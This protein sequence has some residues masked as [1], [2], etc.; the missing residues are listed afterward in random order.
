MQ[1]AG[2]VDA[3]ELAGESEIITGIGLLPVVLAIASGVMH[4]ELYGDLY[5]WPSLADSS[6]S[7]S[8]TGSSESRGF[9][10]T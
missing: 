7:V 2:T 9:T 3:V 6:S 1:G 5:S 8:D 10:S 4:G